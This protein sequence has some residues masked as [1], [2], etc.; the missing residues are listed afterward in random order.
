MAG[1]AQPEEHEPVGQ[2]QAR[3][4]VRALD[5]HGGEARHQQQRGGNQADQL[6]VARPHP[7]TWPSSN[8]LISFVAAVCELRLWLSSV[9]RRSAGIERRR[10]TGHVERLVHRDPERQHVRE[11]A[12]DRDHS[13]RVGPEEVELPAGEIAGA[14]EE[15]QNAGRPTARPI[16]NFTGR[17]SCA[18]GLGV[19]LRPRERDPAARPGRRRW[20]ARGR[21][22]RPDRSRSRGGRG[23]TAR[24][25]S[26]AGGGGTACV[27]TVSCSSPLDIEPSRSRRRGTGSR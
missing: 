7:L 9:P 13:L 21:G 16:T 22:A 5:E 27:I 8:W 3:N 11:S 10:Q 25:S 18:L 2:R 6:P 1:D 12:V 15:E 19:A 4:R 20:R 23:P 17:V 24:C 26:A 14:A